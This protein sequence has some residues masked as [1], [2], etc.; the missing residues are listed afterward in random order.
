[1][2][3]N[4]LSCVICHFRFYSLLKCCNKTNAL[5]F[6]I[7]YLTFGLVNL[8]LF[9]RQEINRSHQVK[10]KSLN[11][12]WSCLNN[13]WT[14]DN[15]DNFAEKFQQKIPWKVLAKLKTPY[16]Q[17]W[18]TFPFSLVPW[19]QRQ[20]L[21]WHIQ[22]TISHFSDQLTIL[23]SSRFWWIL[24]SHYQCCSGPQ[25][26]LIKIKQAKSATDAN[27]IYDYFLS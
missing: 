20:G 16:I 10:K 27:Q 18:R 17:S 8:Q 21:F 7:W 2:G 12:S 11:L 22:I 25:T 6:K 9:C 26:S 19:V 5:A 14:G 24:F 3:S 15:F 23:F 13:D 1:M 4:Q